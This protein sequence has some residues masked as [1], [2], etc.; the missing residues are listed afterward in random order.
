MV[1][2]IFQSV[3][4]HMVCQNLSLIALAVVVDVVEQMECQR[5]IVIHY[6]Q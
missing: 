1:A 4:D 3:V 2:Q 6:R 5:H